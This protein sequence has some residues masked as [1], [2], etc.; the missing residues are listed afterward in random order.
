MNK[1]ATLIKD[2]SYEDATLLKKDVDK[3][4]LNKLLKKRIV[5]AKRERI[6]LCPVCNTPV[7]ESLGIY[8]EFGPEGL[9]KKATFDKNEC[10]LYFFTEKYTP[11]K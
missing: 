5:E 7:Q 11:H 9:R 4:N 10:L 6:S 8:V 2:L 3:G 1:L